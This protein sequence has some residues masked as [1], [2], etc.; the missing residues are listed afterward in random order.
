[1]STNNLELALKIK[2]L[3]DGIKNVEALAA[4]LRT[5]TQAS[6]ATTTD[7]TS[8]LRDGLAL[9]V[10]AIREVALELNKLLNGRAKAAD[11]TAAVRE[12]VEHTAVAVREVTADL[13]AL[14]QQGKKVDDPTA[15]ARTGIEQTAEVVRE[16][17]DGLDALGQGEKKVEDPTAVARD[18]IEQTGKALQ[19]RD[20]EFEQLDENA[21]PAP[22]PTGNIRRGAL[23]TVP[24]LD[25]LGAELDQVGATTRRGLPDPTP[26]LRQGL[27]NVLAVAEQTRAGLS[28]IASEIFNLR[29]AIAAGVVGIATKQIVDS[30]LA[31]ERVE[32][33]LKAVTGSAEGGAQE[34]A[35]VRSE[36]DRLGLALQSTAEQYTQLTAAA[37]GTKLEGQ[38]IRDIFSAI[39]ETTTV[40]GKTEAETTGILNALQQ[41]ISKGVVSSEELRQQLGDRLPGAVQAA[42]R[43]LGV[44]TGQLNKMLEQGQILTDDFLPR[45]AAEYR[46]TFGSEVA[47]ATTSAQ[48]ELNRFSTTVFDLK[49]EFAKSGFLSGLISGLKDL[50]VIL[51]DPEFKASLKELGE[52]LGALLVKTGQ[53]VGGVKLILSG[54]SDPLMKLDYEV[55]RVD[56]KIKDLQEALDKPFVLRGV[57]I[58]DPKDD[59]GRTVPSEERLFMSDEAINKRLDELRKQRQAIVGDMDKIIT[60]RGKKL[61][62]PQTP[63]AETLPPFVLP[64]SKAVLDARLAELRA[65][66]DAQNRLIKDNLAR[67]QELLDQQLAENLISYRAYYAQR[68]QLQTEAA[69]QELSA[70]RKELVSQNAAVKSAKAE[71]DRLE[72]L[73]KVHKLE[74]DIVIVERQRGAIA[75]KAAFDQAQAEKQLVAELTQ[76]HAALLQAQGR[77]AD[78]QALQ[79]GQQYGELIKKL[80]VEGDAAGEELVRKL[81]NVEAARAQLDQLR[82]EYDRVLS[83]MQVDEQRI[84]NDRDAGLKTELQARKEIVELHRRTSAQL[85]VLVPQMQ[86]LG[87]AVGPDAANE[88]A[89]IAEE[90]RGLGL[91][92]DDVAARVNGSL[93][94]GLTQFFDA[95]A[96][97]T[98]SGKALIEDFGNS[99]IA[100]I[101][102]IAAEQAATKI[103]AAGGA[104]GGGRGGGG[105]GGGGAPAPVHPAGGVVGAVAASRTVAPLAFVSAPRYHSGGVLGLK[106]DEVPAILQRGEE[107]LTCNDPR[108]RDNGG[109]GGSNVNVHMTINTTND[110]SFRRSQ[111]R[112]ARDMAEAARRAQERHS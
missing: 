71:D 6:N 77:S 75:G 101:N 10:T 111:G 98:K 82:A 1:M 21:K 25:K 105:G 50:A 43:A 89:R 68:A 34:L 41:M 23:I 95:I 90:V 80:Q 97:G 9:T 51:K 4:H 73:A 5:L 103:R 64:P 28:R 12:G 72:A 78:A 45:F 29:N 33:G 81:I 65:A 83:Q 19:V 20:A 70:L 57:K 27:K 63:T 44:T 7:S 69:D 56:A 93:E 16:V 13:D 85:G 76:V 46:K 24:P 17:G 66:V 87:K 11:P 14:S 99:V 2:V 109:M 48:A 18:C 35:F 54:P 86:A 107:V 104:A 3:V 40:L 8:E 92:V 112:I 102:R 94:T 110:D 84:S 26:A 30:A 53:F 100:T 47:A 42:A 59:L 74:A 108:H 15:A 61:A 62:T 39:I 52:N 37:K 55:S 22:D 31:Y 58:R 49:V 38:G 67:Q 96:K 106:P 32:R 88:V 79:L 36:A 60:E 91:T